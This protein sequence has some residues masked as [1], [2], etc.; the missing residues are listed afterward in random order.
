MHPILRLSTENVLHLSSWLI[1]FIRKHVKIKKKSLK[2]KKDYWTSLYAIPLCQSS[3]VN[4]NLYYFHWTDL[5]KSYIKMALPV[6]T[7][8]RQCVLLQN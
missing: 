6:L 1:Y 8:N 4:L 5:K 2:M 7:E 3:Y